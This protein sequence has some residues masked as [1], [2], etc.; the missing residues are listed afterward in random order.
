MPWSH[1]AILPSGAKIGLATLKPLPRAFE[2]KMSS[3]SVGVLAPSKRP[4]AGTDV[5]TAT[6]AA[7]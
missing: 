1:R 7:I 2:T 3:A 6:G 5:Q 4:R